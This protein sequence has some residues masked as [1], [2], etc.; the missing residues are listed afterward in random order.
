[1]ARRGPAPGPAVTALASGFCEVTLQTRDPARLATFY[2]RCLQLERL[3]ADED[4]VW[5]AV[6]DNARLGLWRPGAKE[7]GDRGGAHVHFALAVA[8]RSLERVG[9]LLAAEGV[10]VSG[11]VTHP[12]GDRSLYATD[13]EGN[14]VEMWDFFARGRTVEALAS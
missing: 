9:E 14:V 7:F 5:L 6:G 3:S 12:G 1:V 11:P 13:P 8:P 2:E 10:E 4:R